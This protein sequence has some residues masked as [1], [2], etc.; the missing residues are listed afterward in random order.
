MAASQLSAA[1]GIDN[2]RTFEESLSGFARRFPVSGRV[3]HA[4]AQEK[5]GVLGLAE[6]LERAGLWDQALQWM[7]TGKPKT[8]DIA[9]LK[10]AFST[11]VLERVGRSLGIPIESVEI[12]AAL[13]IPK[14]FAT[15]A[16]AGDDD[17]S[18]T[19]SSRSRQHGSRHRSPP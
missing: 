6:I 11:E 8:L 4:L 9:D 7:R 19:S 14:F 5:G 10:R 13:G 12:Q 3:V 15:L 18:S 2:T 17:L 16:Q 1:I